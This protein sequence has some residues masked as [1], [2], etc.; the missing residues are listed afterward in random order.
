[1]RHELRRRKLVE[2]GFKKAKIN[3][4]EL[5]TNTF[6]V[7]QGEV[8]KTTR[9][10]DEM[11][12]YRRARLNDRAYAAVVFGNFGTVNERA[13]METAV[14]EGRMVDALAMQEKILKR[15]TDAMAQLE[16]FL[17]KPENQK[18]E[19]VESIIG[20][21]Y[22]GNYDRLN[23]FA[24][25]EFNFDLGSEAYYIPLQRLEAIGDPMEQETIQ[26]VFSSAGVVQSIGKGF[27][28]S[29]IDIAP[30]HQKPVKAGL[31]KTWDQMVTKQEH[32]MA[33]AGYLR[34]MRNIFQGRGSE[35][36]MSN[37]KRRFSSAATDYITH[38]ISELANPNP[39]RDYTNLD[40]VNRLMRGHYP[41]AVLAFRLSSIIKQAFTSPPPFLQ[42]VSAGQYIQAA[43][44]CLSEDT[45]NMIREKSVYMASRV[46]DP[47]NEFI[48]E[49]ELSSFMGKS[50]K[51]QAA[52]I[53]A[54][55]IGMKGLE[56]ID[57]VCVMPGWRAAYKQKAA[58]LNGKEGFDQNTIEAEAVKYADQVVRDTQP[59]SRQVD[60][61]PLFKHQKNPFMQMFLQFQVPQSVIMQNLFVDAPNNFKQGQRGAALT[62]I[63]IY[64]LT[65]AAVG[66]LEEDEDDEKFNLKYRGIDAAVG[67]LESIP[68]A[69]GYAAYT[70]EHFLRTG[71]V[72]LSQ[73][74]P[75]PVVDEAFRAGAAVTQEQW[76][77][78]FIR[79]L[80]ALGYYTGGPVGAVGEIEKAVK[81]GNPW[82]LLGLK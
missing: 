16:E 35:V 43:M 77:Q 57:S 42:F 48:K 52:L 14:E 70:V 62:T 27:T 81:E 8:A 3:L 7:D 44:E 65:A 29:R 36:L 79:S 33:Y 47:A 58:E 25:R 50:G 56:W 59:S 76:D 32:L 15:Y 54:E 4:K 9:S 38:Y 19:A 30:W 10:L 60:L 28:L 21:D 41:A 39:Q 71:K 12:F 31:Y 13:A 40:T 55:R 37:I 74:K 23:E 64:G 72:K 63:A 73:F 26:E 53:K 49:L 78:A 51:A 1:M 82:I 6:S 45:R 66:L 2:E 75:F 67:Y 61:A 34:E 5:W 17:A 22:D 11:L 80:K 69:G 68:I 18:F 20:R 24:A 46:I